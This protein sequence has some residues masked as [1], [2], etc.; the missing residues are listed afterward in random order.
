MGDLC[1]AYR[2]LMTR[3]LLYIY[4]GAGSNSTCL[5]LDFCLAVLVTGHWRHPRQCDDGM[6]LLPPSIRLVGRKPTGAKERTV[7]TRLA[8]IYPARQ[9]RQLPKKEVDESSTPMKR[10]TGAAHFDIGIMG[11][12]HCTDQWPCSSSLLFER[13]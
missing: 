12:I 5:G 8:P 6:L 3:K 2:L 1:L 13:V 9:P 10:D 11:Y 4:P 7:C